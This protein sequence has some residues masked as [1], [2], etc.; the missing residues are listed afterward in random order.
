MTN[1]E[2]KTS[3]RPEDLRL[4]E[5]VQGKVT[6]DYCLLGSQRLIFPQRASPF[7]LPTKVKAKN[8][9]LQRWLPLY[10]FCI[11]RS[12]NTTAAFLAL[13]WPPCVADADI[14]FSSCGYF[15]LSFLLHFAWVVDDAKCIEVT[16]VCVCV[17]VSVCLFVC[18]S[19]RGRMPTLLRGPGWN[20]GS[21]IRDA[22]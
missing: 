4:P 11:F 6:I 5:H 14:I 9:F 17:C 16:R 1:F 2:L 13:L 8:T 20:L 7:S 21:R 3:F 19:V 18:L 12:S 22:P 10:L 15:C